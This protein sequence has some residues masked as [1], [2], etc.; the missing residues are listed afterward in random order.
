MKAAADS[1]STGISVVVPVL[2]AAGTL[3]AL[4]EALASQQPAPPDEI[5]LV[6][7]L[8]TDATRQIARQHANVRV[9]P[10]GRFSHGR[11]RNLGAQESSGRIIVL[12][13]QDALPADKRWLAALLEPFDDEQVAAVYSRQI[14]RPNAPPTERFFLQYHFPP[15]APVRRTRS[16]QTSAAT[17]KLPDVFFSNV[18]AAVRREALLS[19]PFDETLIMS[20]DQQF[21]RDL[22]VAGYA[23]VYQPASVVIHSHRYSL[24]TAF[25]RYFDSVYSL[26][27]IFP[28]HDLK[29][30][31]GMGRRYLREEAAYILRQHPFY[32]PYYCLYTLCKVSGVLCSH[33]AG[34]MPKGLARA[35]SLHR[36]YW[37]HEPRDEHAAGPPP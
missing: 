13:T 18:S 29:V 21:A 2:N 28:A 14:P 25:R 22:I 3:P 31:A 16:A 35:C 5:V 36:Y 9:V 34:R 32:F 17:L 33:V 4:L 7:S 8:S 15:G 27:R 12:M 24:L 10:L 20:E 1:N 30:S 11:A 37:E 19:Y 26:T 23:I 6:D